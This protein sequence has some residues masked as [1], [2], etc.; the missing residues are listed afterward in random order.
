M[1]G[2]VACSLIFYGFGY[3][4][5]LVFG[6]ALLLGITF[7]VY[8]P[9]LLALPN[10]YGYTIS[11]KNSSNLMIAYATGESVVS[12]LV[13]FL[14]RFHPIMLYVT[15][16][17]AMIINRYVFGIVLEELKIC[18]MRDEEKKKPLIEVE[19]K[20]KWFDLD[21]AKLKILLE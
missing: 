8:F 16:L 5:L 10:K 15:L 7:S 9:Y 4:I 3:G 19:M 14:M 6:S 13:G 21:C 17:I 18:Q 20:E 2:I 11:A 12:A 1:I